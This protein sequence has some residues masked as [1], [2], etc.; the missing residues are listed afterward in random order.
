MRHNIFGFLG[1]TTEHHG[2]EQQMT[3]IASQSDGSFDGGEC[4][5][6]HPTRRFIY[7]F[8]KETMNKAESSGMAPTN[9][10]GCMNRSA[11]IWFVHGHRLLG[12]VKL[13]SRRLIFFAG[14]KLPSNCMF[15]PSI[16]SWISLDGRE[17]NRKKLP[18]VNDDCH[19]FAVTR[20]GKHF[21]SDLA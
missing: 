5:V 10:Y 2:Q 21:Q 9:Q 18:E 11:H 20:F 12:D 6:F 1:K 3:P 4:V 13:G 15:S 7:G 14:C 8:V 16:Q 17:I 19:L